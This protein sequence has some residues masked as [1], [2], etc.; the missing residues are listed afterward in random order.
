MCVLPRRRGD[1]QGNSRWEVL[2][3]TMHTHSQ[4]AT[5]AVYVLISPGVLAELPPASLH[6]HT[7]THTAPAPPG[8]SWLRSDVR[9]PAAVLCWRAESAAARPHGA[10]HVERG[11]RRASQ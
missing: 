2:L 5:D 9:W 10:E 3:R 7:H 8:G 11:R 1:P 6:T 4:P